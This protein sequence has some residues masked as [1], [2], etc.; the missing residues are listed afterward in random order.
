MVGGDDTPD[1]VYKYVFKVDDSEYS[2]SIYVGEQPDMITI[3]VVST[4]N[5]QS[6]N[7]TFVSDGC[8]WC[9]TTNGMSFEI[10]RNEENIY[11]ECNVTY[12]QKRNNGQD[13]TIVLTI[14]QSSGVEL[15][16]YIVHYYIVDTTTKLLDDTIVEKD[17]TN[18]KYKRGEVVEITAKQQEITYNNEN[19][20]LITSSPQSITITNGE[21]EVAFYYNTEDIGYEFYFEK[22]PNYSKLTTSINNTETTYTCKIISNKIVNGNSS[23]INFTCK[24]SDNATVNNGELTLTLDTNNT[25]VNKTYSIELTQDESGNKLYIEITQ[26]GEGIFMSDYLTLKYTWSSGK[27]LDTATVLR[28]PFITEKITEDN[29]VGF[30]L[31][32]SVSYEGMECLVYGGDNKNSGD[33]GAL[34]EF[35]KISEYINN[36]TDKETWCKNNLANDNDGNGYYLLFDIYANWFEEYSDENVQITLTSNVGASMYIHNGYTFTF[37]GGK[38]ST[39]SAENASINAYSQLNIKNVDEGYSKIAYVKYY[40]NS[41]SAKLVTNTNSEWTD[42][43]LIGVNVQEIS[44]D[45]YNGVSKYFKAQKLKIQNY[46]GSTYYDITENGE[47]VPIEGDTIETNIKFVIN[48]REIPFNELSVEI[49]STND[50]INEGID[51]IKIAIPENKDAT[52]VGRTTVGT[53]RIIPKNFNWIKTYIGNRTTSYDHSLIYQKTIEKEAQKYIQSRSYVYSL[54]DMNNTLTVYP[55]NR[56][57]TQK[58]YDYLYVRTTSGTCSSVHFDNCNDI[59]RTTIYTNITNSETKIDFK[60]SDIEHNLTTWNKYNLLCVSDDSNYEGTGLGY[61]YV[62]FEDSLQVLYKE[63]VVRMPQDISETSYYLNEVRP[64]KLWIMAESDATSITLDFNQKVKVEEG[65]IEDWLNLNGG[66]Y[67]GV[68]SITLSIQQNNTSSQ[69]DVNTFTVKSL[70]NDCEIIFWIGQHNKGN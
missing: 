14:V 68:T 38:T 56:N 63:N 13:K 6:Y 5:G 65:K 9:K 61:V 17:Y 58:I 12:T 39:V 16:G 60:T 41:C 50:L 62:D 8:D 23:I 21:N 29:A 20:K 64:D 53:I 59:L 19:Y 44:I 3:T 70:V 55:Y 28:K 7:W 33:E 51:H 52:V 18:K 40:V 1:T 26:L 66:V 57:M 46:A 69:R 22:Y 34:I 43:E 25:F 45:G 36:L 48:N 49:D 30:N 27:D 47:Y 67:E 2:H 4:E 54:I 31:S 35:I 32:T 11:R 15:F 24:P 10:K 37:N 42:T